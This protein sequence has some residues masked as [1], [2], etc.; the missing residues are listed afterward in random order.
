VGI[1]QDLA[2]YCSELEYRQLPEEG[3]DRA[4]YF[5]L[6][7]IGVACRGSKEDSSQS[8]YRFIQETG[9]GNR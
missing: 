5:F 2:K 3:V 8:M 4:K 6:D 9:S 1:T 7:F